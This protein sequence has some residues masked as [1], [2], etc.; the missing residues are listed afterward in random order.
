MPREVFNDPNEKPMDA[1][2]PPEWLA[3]KPA[4][5]LAEQLEPSAQTP[6]GKRMHDIADAAAMDVRKLVKQGER[7]MRPQ[8]VQRIK[9][10]YLEQVHDEAPGIPDEVAIDRL[11]A[12]LQDAHDVRF[13]KGDKEGAASLDSFKRG[14]DPRIEVTSSFGAGFLERLK[15]PEFTSPDQAQEAL[16]AERDPMKT[17]AM[18]AKQILDAAKGGS[19]AL[20]DTQRKTYEDNIRRYEQ[21][22]NE[23]MT[24]EDAISERF[25][26]N[27]GTGS[28]EMSGQPNCF[29][30]SINTCM[31]CS[32][33][34]RR[35]GSG[36]TRL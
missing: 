7:S 36:S 24:I 2:K 11:K 16:N 14:L 21:L 20:N 18:E 30:F 15:G 28:V 35:A 26:G 10:A 32:P 12:V 6:E 5:D 22:A 31:R 19:I 27:V 3:E 17:L 33:R 1:P 13:D 29:Q 9:D 23:A 34:R 4:S 25:A 8:D